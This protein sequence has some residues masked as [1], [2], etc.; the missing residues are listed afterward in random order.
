[1]WDVDEQKPSV[2][3]ILQAGEKL[4]VSPYNCVMIDDAECGIEDAKK[5]RALAIDVTW[6]FHSYKKSAMPN[7]IS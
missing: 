6:G 7:L 5:L 4:N 3:P 2:E 1:L